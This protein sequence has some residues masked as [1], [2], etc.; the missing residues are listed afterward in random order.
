M[1]VLITGISGFIGK[2]LAIRLN[3]EA[4][5]DCVGFT[6]VDS[7]ADLRSKLAVAD[8]V[9][10]LAGENRPPDLSA[11]V[12]GN[13]KLTETLCHEIEQSGRLIP[14]IL[15]S[16]TQAELDSPY[17]TSKLNAEKAVQAF[18][19][20]T[21]T[22]AIIYRLPN[23]FGK[24]SRANYNSVVA[25]FCHNVA[26]S[27]PLRIDD[28]QSLVRLIYIDDVI[29]EI[30]SK[31][32]SGFSGLSYEKVEPEH[33]ISVGDLADQINAFAQSRINL[34][35]GNV[36]QGLV[37]ALYSTYMSFLPTTSFAYDIP[38]YG[39]ERGLFVEMLKTPDCG[40]FSFFT[41]HPGITRGSHY[42]HS[43][44]EKFLVIKGSA[45]F[46]FRHILTDEYV[47]FVV[48][49]EEPRI[50]ETIPGWAHDI[51]NIGEDELIVMLWANEIFDRNQPD[52][53]ASEVK[54]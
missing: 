25:T 20:K 21:D 6:R 30:L 37:R 22:P 15:A 49:G 39:D 2:N 52:T 40:Q 5:F 31:L 27:I 46:G 3:E 7:L 18:S 50:V 47:E 44:T 45:R 19:E 54:L 16:S 24:W 33:L 26:R 38:S 48:S 35:T 9:V 36:G 34:T 8:A 51:A 29:A 42:H 28:P 41:A 13:T 11:F 12:D 1:R 53:I 17:G 14:F 23:V 4:G 32:K 43:K 10:H